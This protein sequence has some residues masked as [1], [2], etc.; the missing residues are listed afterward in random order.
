MWS[1]VEVFGTFIGCIN[2]LFVGMV[3]V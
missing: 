3:I 1:H 2:L